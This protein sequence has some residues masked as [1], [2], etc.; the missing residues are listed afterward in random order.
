MVESKPSDLSGVAAIA[1]RMETA[2]NQCDRHGAYTDSRAMINGKPM[3]W[4][5]CPRC[6]QDNLAKESADQVQ[7]ASPEMRMRA[8]E[9][10]LGRSR[11]PPRF[12]NKTFDNYHASTDAHARALA[13]AKAYANQFAHNLEH[14]VCMAFLGKPGTGKTHLAAA[15]ARVIAE[16]GHTALYINTLDY[17]R[18]VR[19]AWAP[20]SGQRELAV[21]QQFVD[22]ELLILD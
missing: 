10:R 20:N 19:E 16:A 7:Q 1:V 17:V 5:G 11:I 9:R 4:A 3:A 18:Q 14:G 12:L 8:M 2:P 6:M 21:I 13:K 22:P 15:I